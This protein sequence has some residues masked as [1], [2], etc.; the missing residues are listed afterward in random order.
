MPRYAK[1]RTGKGLT[2]RLAFRVSEGERAELIAK[3][4]KAGMPMSEYLR[5]CIVGNR[6]QVIERSVVRALLR[7]LSAIGNNINQIA[8]QNHIDHHEGRVSEAS[9]MAQLS[10]LVS[11]QNLLDSVLKKC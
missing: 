8:K 11:M 4:D 10:A 9:H 6:T 7:E 2:E 1:T 3:A 5:E